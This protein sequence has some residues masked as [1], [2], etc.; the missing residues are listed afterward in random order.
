M[1]LTTPLA[2]QNR[3]VSCIDRRAALQAIAPSEVGVRGHAGVVSPR[4]IGLCFDFAVTEPTS[5]I[6]RAYRVRLRLKP[7]QERRLLRLFG[8]RRYVWNWALRRKDEA[9]R[10]DGTKLNAVSLS[11]EFTQLT[12]GTGEQ[13]IGQLG[14]AELK[15]GVHDRRH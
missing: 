4:A 6:E 2:E 14:D 1:T 9:W 7:A 10:A 12:V 15:D 13:W 3:S 11:R 8:A 5:T